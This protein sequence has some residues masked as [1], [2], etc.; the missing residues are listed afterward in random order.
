MPEGAKAKDILAILLISSLAVFY[1]W[2]AIDGNLLLTERDLSVFFIPPRVFWTESL[3]SGE[4]PLWNP[5]SFS[6]HPLFATLQP[7]VLYP[8]NLLLIFLPFDIAFNW[9]IIIHYVLAGVFTFF[10]LREMRADVA[11]S[12]AG[13]IVFMLSGYLFSV[14]NVMSTLFSAAWVPL[15]LLMHLRAARAGAYAYALG[16]GLV[17]T[18]IFLGGGIEVLFGTVILIFMTALYPRILLI[19]DTKAGLFSRLGLFALSIFSFLVFSAVGLLPFL[20]LAAQ[21]TRASGL[22]FFEATT[23][24]FHGKD[25]IQF[26]IPD[27]YGYGTSNDKYWSNQSWLKTVYLGTVPFMLALFFFLKNR[28]KALPFTFAGIL[29]LLLAMGRNTPLYQILYD[30][31]PFIGK[32]RY[33]VKFLLVPFLFIAIAAG[34]GLEYVKEKAKSKDVGLSRAVKAILAFATLAAILLGLLDLFEPDVKA[35]LVSNGF[36]YPEYN[37]AGINIFNTKRVL[38]L[39]IVAAISLYAG[40]KTKSGALIALILV[41]ILSIDLF[42]AHNGYYYAT[43]AGDY[44]AKGPVLEFI[45]KDEGGPFRVFTTPKTAKGDSIKLTE[46]QKKNIG[47]FNADKEKVSGFNIEHNV[48]DANGVD[49]MRRADYSLIQELIATQPGPDSTKLLSMLNVKYLISIPEIESPDWK[50]S[51]L[52]GWSSEAGFKIYENMDYLPRHYMVY[53]Y[54]VIKKPDAVVNSLLDKAFHPGRTVLLESE[55]EGISRDTGPGSFNVWITG[56]RNNSSELKVATEKDGV[57]VI[58]ESWYPGWKVFVDGKE[59]K[60]LKADLVLKAVP[61]RAGEHIVRLVYSP[62]LF[63]IGAAITMTGLALSIVFLI[64]R[65][66][67]GIRE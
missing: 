25:F 12:L 9:T 4:F 42:F 22:S 61:L 38:F 2:S 28:R 20:E 32:V 8:I 39:F 21:S 54:K 66:R 53:D 13:A 16:E 29:F 43:R 47:R 67:K 52:K 45:S 41:S 64:V 50:K 48:F 49:V 36:D 40:V 30:Y 19:E 33:P 65:Y 59:E 56:Y 11:G 26:F 34:V 37:M 55:P 60:L 14:H 44:H 3:L 46:E 17:F 57:L 1:F 63:K 18:M 7:G 5:Y 58:S 35:Y 31:M 6:G 51:D 27:P 62:A 10:L 15:A 23:W 24:S